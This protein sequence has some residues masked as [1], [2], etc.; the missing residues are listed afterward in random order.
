MST[1]PDIVDA[2]ARAYARK[3]LPKVREFLLQAAAKIGGVRGERIRDVIGVSGEAPAQPSG[4]SLSPLPSSGGESSWQVVTPG[5]SPFTP[6]R[7][8]SELSAW[9]TE[10]RHWQALDVAGE[11]LFPLL[12]VGPPRCGKT[13][14][15]ASLSSALG[16][17]LQRM[18]NSGMVSSYM[19]DSARKMRA[20]LD[21][22]M[23]MVTSVCLIDELDGLVPARGGSRGADSKERDHTVGCLLTWLEELPPHL[24]LIATT[25]RLDAVDPA[26]A[27]RMTVVTW[28]EWGELSAEER[29]AFCASHG[30]TGS[31]FESYADAVVH[32]RRQRVAE[33]I[34]QRSDVRAAE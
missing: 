14:S 20:A 3:D 6:A 25:N 32:A 19:G 21:A 22:T 18:N 28:P 7:V 4:R 16:R 5:R 13:S 2:C 17:T 24:A 33:F 11:R 1:M 34:A 15:A 26:V 29:A 9:A 23:W 30:V 31:G 8:A 27:A 10:V 12:L